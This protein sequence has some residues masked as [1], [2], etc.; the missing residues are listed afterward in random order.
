M[1]DPLFTDLFRDTEKLSWDPAERVRDRGRRRTR[2][3]RIMAGLGGAVAVAV[4]VTGAAALGNGP[5][6]T[7][8]APPVPSSPA[9]SP[10]PSPARTSPSPSPS[11]PPSVAPTS[12]SRPATSA[13]P[14][15][16]AVPKAA[17]LQPADLPEGF[18]ANGSDLDGDWSLEAATI[19]CSNKSPRITPGEV[20][21]RGAR[22]QASEEFVIQ[23]VTRHSGGNAGT[24]MDRVRELVS[25]CVP[26]EGMNKLSIVASGLSGE[27]SLL[28]GS[29]GGYR[30]VFVRQGDLVAQVALGESATTAE[31]RRYAQRTANRLCAGTDAC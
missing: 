11:R 8:P 2:R 26:Y 28:I 10:A 7:P 6:P 29:S 9:P 30:W 31:A 12:P 13:P 4:I 24:A 1:P 18:R 14:A 21:R 23:R 16:P 5:D 22:F 19:A 27:E 20:A 3:T 17:M 25:E 15:G